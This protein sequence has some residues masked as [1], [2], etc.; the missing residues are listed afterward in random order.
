MVRRRR[1]VDGLSWCCSSSDLFCCRYPLLAQ[2]YGFSPPLTG[3]LAAIKVGMLWGR[4]ADRDKR[5]QQDIRICG[6][7]EINKC[8]YM[9]IR[10]SINGD[11]KIR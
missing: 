7:N 10:K 4:A 2:S 9:E 5:A 11:M 3:M 8:R 6:Y 1:C